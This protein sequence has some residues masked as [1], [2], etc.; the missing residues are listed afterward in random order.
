MDLSTS[1]EPVINRTARA[2][3]RIAMPE[4]SR[5]YEQDTEWCVVYLDGQ[6]QEIR[7]HDYRQIY[8]VEG[9]YEHLF[10]DILECRS[11]DILAASFEAQ[12]Q[13]AGTAP[14]ELRVLDLGAG[15]GI[16]GEK[17]VGL[18]VDFVV[19]VDILPEACRAARRDR[20]EVYHAYHVVDMSD[21]PPSVHE[22]LSQDRLNTLTCVAALG[23]AD[24]PPDC[25]TAAFNLICDSGWVV[26]TIKDDFLSDGDT[27]GF[28]RL[29]SDAVENGL[30]EL[31]W[32]ERYQ[33]RLATDRTP[34]RYTG[35]IGRKR[36]DLPGG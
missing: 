30:L 34:L 20:P 1:Q 31:L 32:I 16:M 11:P 4:L 35:V 15:N 8:D 22:A 17:L 19:G 5:R 12:L 2:D 26:F 18:G 24:I 27:T 7:F 28:A 14:D 33:H 21:L 36:G 23:F 9:L 10:Y 25:F 13:R 3:L 29:I 6:W